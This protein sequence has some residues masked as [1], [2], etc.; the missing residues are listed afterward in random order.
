MTPQE[1]RKVSLP[2]ELV[3]EA[4]ILARNKKLGYTST[5]D[6][7][8]DA[9]RILINTLKTKETYLSY[10]HNNKK[11]KGNNASSYAWTSL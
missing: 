4:E 8:R 3:D 5:S 6:L 2:K 10:K 7:I 9:T 1:Y 11:D